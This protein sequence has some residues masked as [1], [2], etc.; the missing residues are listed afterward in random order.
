MHKA[1]FMMTARTQL[2][3][4]H[5]HHKQQRERHANPSASL[6]RFILIQKSLRALCLTLHLRPGRRRQ[7]RLLGGNVAERALQQACPHQNGASDAH[8]HHVAARHRCARSL[9]NGLH[10]RCGDACYDEVGPTESPRIRFRARSTR[11]KSKPYPNFDKWVLTAR[12]RPRRTKLPPFDQ[13]EAKEKR[14][15]RESY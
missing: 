9:R 7:L 6:G 5:T 3:P 15:Y 14:R 10:L 11:L 13:K 12:R 4:S 1:A 8:D 2:S